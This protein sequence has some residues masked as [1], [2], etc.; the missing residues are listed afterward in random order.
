MKIAQNFTIDKSIFPPAGIYTDTEGVGLLATDIVL[1]LTSF[2]A[3]IAIIMIITSGIKIVIS[4]GDEKKLQQA[5]STFNYAII[6]LVVVI[7]SFVIVRSIQF[8]I[9]SGVDI[10]GG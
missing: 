8:F 1:I 7:L 4:S 9:G 3:A 10:T 2:A 5:M 6:G